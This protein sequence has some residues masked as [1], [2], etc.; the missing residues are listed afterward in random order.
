MGAALKQQAALR[1]LE[2]VMRA[3]AE[4]YG[5]VLT[6]DVPA[7]ILKPLRQV[8]NG[9]YGGAAH[10]RGVYRCSIEHWKP[11]SNCTALGCGCMQPLPWYQL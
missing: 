8:R 10:C 2:F 1:S 7:F 9:L 3:S 4:H 11:F 5:N 6:P